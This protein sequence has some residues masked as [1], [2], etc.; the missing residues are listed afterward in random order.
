[1]GVRRRTIAL[2]SECAH[3]PRRRQ[4]CLVSIHEGEGE[5]ARTEEKHDSRARRLRTCQSL[6]FSL[7]RC[8]FRA[9][10][11]RATWAH[12]LFFPLVA[13]LLHARCVFIIFFVHEWLW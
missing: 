11:I 6:R 5:C 3:R 4:L 9:L 12:F 8:D 1:M 10:P 13:L 2:R 7:L